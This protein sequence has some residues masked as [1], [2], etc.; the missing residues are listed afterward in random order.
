MGKN[1]FDG[2]VE[3][4]TIFIETGEPARLLLYKNEK[5]IPVKPNT[6]YRISNDKGYSTRTRM[7]MIIIKTI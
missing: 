4:G 5:L 1:F 3:L 2:E 6:T 7:L